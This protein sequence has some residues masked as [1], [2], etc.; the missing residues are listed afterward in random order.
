MKILEGKG[1]IVLRGSLDVAVLHVQASIAVRV[2]TSAVFPRLPFA[3][4][5]TR[6][7]CRGCID[8]PVIAEGVGGD[9]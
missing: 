2:I 8:V 3:C 5:V 6:E 7:E 9:R 1:L 4:D